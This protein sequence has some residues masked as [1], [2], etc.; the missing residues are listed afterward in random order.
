M[1]EE[2]DALRAELAA[3]KR[4][5]DGP[6]TDLRPCQEG[7]RAQEE[8]RAAPTNDE[9]NRSFREADLIASIVDGALGGLRKGYDPQ[10]N[11]LRRGKFTMTSP[12]WADN[13]EDCLG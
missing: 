13:P 5:L 11:V 12:S 6:A 2:I 10:G 4:R 7:Y 1:S 8:A 9:F 3:L